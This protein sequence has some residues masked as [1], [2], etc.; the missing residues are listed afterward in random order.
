MAEILEDMLINRKMCIFET[1]R[2]TDASRKF[3][4]CIYQCLN[5]F[6]VAI[7]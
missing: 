6:N 2:S 1:A 7:L 5:L 3:I 4:L